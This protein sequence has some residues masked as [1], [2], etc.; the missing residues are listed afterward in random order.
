M[1]GGG[2][3][4]SYGN[5]LFRFLRDLHIVFH[6]GCTNLPSHQQCRSVS[7]PLY[8]PQHLSLFVLLMI[9]ILTGVRWNL[10]VILICIFFIA[11]NG[12]RFFIY[13]LAIC[14]SSFDNFLFSSFA[15][16]VSGLLI[17]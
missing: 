11:K 7:F 8:P 4:G 15:L 16:L 9:A 13:L 10:D 14:T 17:L 3:A 12:E 6:S 2:I 1:P 5:P